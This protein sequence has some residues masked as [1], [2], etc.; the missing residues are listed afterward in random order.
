MSLSELRN[1]Y[2][3]IIINFFIFILL[4]DE[5]MFVVWDNKFENGTIITRNFLTMGYYL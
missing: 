1:M 2:F 5:Y 3:F 4:F